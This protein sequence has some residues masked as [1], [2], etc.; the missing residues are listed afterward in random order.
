MAAGRGPVGDLRLRSSLRLRRHLPFTRSWV[1]TGHRQD[2]CPHLF[3][4]GTSLEFVSQYLCVRRPGPYAVGGFVFYRMLI[5]SKLVN[6][7]PPTTY[8]RAEAVIF[9]IKGISYRENVLSGTKALYQ[10]VLFRLNVLSRTKLQHSRGGC[11]A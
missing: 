9:V 11:V 10:Y 6:F 8:P 7:Y 5:I 2:L 3:V 4:T 1:T